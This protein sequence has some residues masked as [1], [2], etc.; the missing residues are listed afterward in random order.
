MAIVLIA[1]GVWLAL[2]TPEA[3]AI[4]GSDTDY[5]CADS[6]SSD[7]AWARVSLG[8]SGMYAKGHSYL[9]DSWYEHTAVRRVYQDSSQVDYDRNYGY[10]TGLGFPDLQL[11]CSGTTTGIVHVEA[12]P[13][14]NPSHDA[15]AW[16][17]KSAGCQS[18]IALDVNGDGEINLR[19]RPTAFDLDADG[20]FELLV[21]WFEHDGLL[22]EGPASAGTM[23]GAQLF[24]DEGGTYANGYEKLR[25][26]DADGDNR[27]SGAELDGLALWV[28]DGNA[29]LSLIHI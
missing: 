25:L 17:E 13:T 29:R 10:A 12:Y 7:C 18:P 24:G 22:Y 1:A 28:D 27:L 3:A 8:V 26:R 23:T 11:W 9:W 20:S 2:G 15:N 19:E 5:D 21:G 14:S 6:G 16:A 4:G